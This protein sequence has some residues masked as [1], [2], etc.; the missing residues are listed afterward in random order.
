MM[1]PRALAVSDRRTQPAHDLAPWLRFLAELAVP[2]VW[3]RERDLPDRELFEVLRRARKLL[4]EASLVL[5]SS[6]PDLAVAAAADGVHLSAR[7]LPIAPIRARWSKRLLI[8]RST[9]NQAELDQARAEQADYV[10]YGPV[11]KPNSKTFFGSEVGLSALGS[12]ARAGLPVLALGGVTHLQV[13][14]IAASGAHGVAAI[15][16]FQ[17]RD[18]AEHLLTAVLAQFEEI[19]TRTPR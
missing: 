3:I 17:D 2:A 15:G 8:G 6:R 4:P 13:A 18:Q 16:A 10:T 5:V 14:A 11:F 7:G 9:H 19:G 12:A 1:L